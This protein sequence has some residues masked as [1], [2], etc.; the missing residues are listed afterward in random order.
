MSRRLLV[1]AASAACLLGFATAKAEPIKAQDGRFEAAVSSSQMSRI[2]IQG[3][4]VVSVRK[5]DDPDGPQIMIEAEETTGDV[6]VAFD[7]DVVG[8]S[9]SVFL[10]TES[11]KTVQGLLRP[12]GGEGTTVLVRLEGSSAAAPAQSGSSLRTDVSNGAP[13]PG[14]QQRSDRRASYPETLTAFIRLMFNGEAP[15]GVSRRA[16]ADEGR[17]AGPFKIGT[18]ELFEVPG[19]RG[20]ILTV[21]N[22]S[23]APQVLAADTFLVAGIL[24]AAASHE[25]LRPRETGRIYLVEETR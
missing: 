11:G 3:E 1:A 25:N 2:A 20:Q 10:V 22:T 12:I 4:K 9:F 18:A 5:V 19:L 14:A 15:D 23:D 16:V 6:F 13:P 17:Q 24:A 21:T 7:G 8:R